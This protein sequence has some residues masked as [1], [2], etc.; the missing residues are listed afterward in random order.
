VW[1]SLSSLVHVAHYA[2]NETGRDCSPMRRVVGALVAW[3]YAPA[4]FAYTSLDL[5][6]R[7]CSGRERLPEI[8]RLRGQLE[9]L[10]VEKAK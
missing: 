2:H 8:E 6:C 4:L 1:A 7:R 9:D 10:V 5:F 3:D